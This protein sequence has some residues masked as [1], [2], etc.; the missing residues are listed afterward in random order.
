MAEQETS[1]VRVWPI[2]NFDRVEKPEDLELRSGLYINPPPLDGRCECCGKHISELKPF[3][4]GQHLAPGDCDGALLVRGSRPDARYD[5]HVARAFEEALKRYATEGYEYPKGWL[6]QKYGKEEGE[7]I[8]FHSQR[9]DTLSSVWQCRDCAALEDDEYF[10]RRR[11]RF[12][13]EQA[14]RQPEESGPQ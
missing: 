1:R 2:L 4:A 14:A 13:E 5:E 8:D 6:I 12:Q 3:G 9:Q 10:E 11:I 7:W